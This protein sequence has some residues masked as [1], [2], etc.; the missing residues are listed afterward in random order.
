MIHLILVFIGGGA[1]CLTRYGI[2]LGFQKLSSSLPWATFLS[3][4]S[5]CLVFALTIFAF[6]NK[7]ESNLRFLLIAFCGGLS[8]FSTFSYE[9]FLLFKSG[10]I[11]VALANILFSITIC[12]LVFYVLVKL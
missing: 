6:Q 3:N 1:G 2:G 4:L 10:M 7:T 9:T 12:L 5:A 11:M 8:T